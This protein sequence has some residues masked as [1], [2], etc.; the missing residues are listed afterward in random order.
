MSQTAARRTSD[1]FASRSMSCRQRPPVPM[2]PMLSFSEAPRAL[3]A[4]TPN[5]ATPA[6]VAVASFRKERRVLSGW[7]VIA[8]PPRGSLQAGPHSIR[9]TRMGR[10]KNGAVGGSSPHGELYQH[11]RE[12]PDA[13]DAVDV[14]ERLVDAAEVIRTDQPVLV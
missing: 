3:T 12:Q 13:D 8:K 11:D 14:E 10:E 2:Q 9:A 6:A 7:R 1:I 4:G 5:V